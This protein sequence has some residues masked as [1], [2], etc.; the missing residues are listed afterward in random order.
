MS[1]SLFA[2]LARRYGPPVDLQSR[3]D[4]LKASLALGAGLLLSNKALARLTRDRRRIIVIG[5]GFSGL[6]CAYELAAAGYDVKVLEARS[7]IGGRVLSFNDSPWTTPFIPGRNVEGGG[8]LIGAN[9]PSWLAYADRFGLEFLDVTDEEDAELPVTFANKRLSQEDAKAL[10]EEM[11]HAFA[12]ITRAAED[13]NPDR[14]W[15][16]PD[17]E[18]LDAMTLLDWSERVDATPRAK[19]GCVI[20]LVADNGV[21]AHMQSWLG[22]LAMVRG[23]GGERFWTETELFRCKGGNQQLAVHLARGLGEDKVLLNHA[24]TRIAEHSGG[25]RVECGDMDVHECDEVVLA[26]PP[27]TWSKVRFEPGLPEALAPQMGTNL[28]NLCHV[29][30]RFWR[31]AR[32]APT[33]LSDGDICWTWEGTDNQPGDKDAA[34]HCF[35]GGPGA[36]RILGYEKDTRER[37][38]AT[39]LGSVYPDFRVQLLDSRFMDWPNDPWT[40]AGY[41]F[42]APGQVTTMGPV[43]AAPHGK[44][45]FAGEHA[46]Y[47]FAGFMEGALTAGITVARRIAARDGVAR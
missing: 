42:P 14:P 9:H 44:L 40:K 29:R 20:Q 32:I 30:E 39:L 16:V 23:G 15:T 2:R 35:S 33:W 18:R 36:Q 3:R 6:A 26:V 43:L 11:D 10:Y 21:A 8:E 28:K 27:S 34:L 22:L 46:C 24:V 7:R 12:S 13:I 31:R 38:Y 47:K 45:H 25:V 41:S 1:I 17:A 5:A 4:M 37:I 19:Y